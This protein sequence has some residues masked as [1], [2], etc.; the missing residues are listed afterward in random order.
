M[1]LN[2]RFSAIALTVAAASVAH[3]APVTF[4]GENQS[5]ATAGPPVTGAPATARASFLSNLTGVSNQNFEGFAHLQAPPLNLSFTGSAGSIAAVLS[6][7]AGTVQNISS[8]G[9]FNTSSSGSKWWDT[10]GSFKIDFTGTEVSAFGFYGTDIGD[11]AGK[12]TISLTDTSNADTILTVNNTVGGNDGS[13]LF[14]GFIDSAKSYKSI[15]FG[16]TSSAGLDTFGFD[17]MVVGDARQVVPPPPSGVPE[18]GSLALVCLSLAGLAAS[19]RR[20][21]RK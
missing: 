3:A 9:R 11:F 4:F 19:T 5:P 2:L 7:S 17:D 15:T 14:W 13:V 12:V 16:N 18:P 1:S 8:T 20:K 10:S 21:A 6:A